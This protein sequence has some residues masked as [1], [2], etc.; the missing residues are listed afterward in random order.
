MAAVRKWEMLAAPK[1]KMS[2]REQKS[3]QEYIQHFLHKTCNWEVSGSHV[4]VM[5]NN[6]KE[7]YNK[8]VQ[9]CFFCYLGKKVCY[10]YKVI[11]ISFFG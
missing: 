1:V 11:I 6:G 10:T 8:T 2:G 7:M 4:I 5:Q 9:S 3:G